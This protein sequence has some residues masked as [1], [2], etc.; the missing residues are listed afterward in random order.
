MVKQGKVTACDMQVCGLRSQTDSANPTDGRAV[1][2]PFGK[3]VLLP[4]NISTC[5]IRKA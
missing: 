1:H 5:D 2:H 3:T 4:Q